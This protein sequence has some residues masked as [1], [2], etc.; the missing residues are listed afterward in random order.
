MFPRLKRNS[1]EENPEVVAGVDSASRKAPE[2]FRITVVILRRCLF[3]CLCYNLII[4]FRNEPSPTCSEL[5]GEHT[6]LAS[7]NHAS[8]RFR[9]Y[10]AAARARSRL[11]RIEE[12]DG[13]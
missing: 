1:H 6:A 5:R 9:F 11:E 3:L 12:T 13:K 2:C 10:R 4:P 7:T 8:N